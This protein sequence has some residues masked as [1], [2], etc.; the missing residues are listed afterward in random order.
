MRCVILHYHILKNAGTAIE[1]VLDRNFG[2]R[3]SRFDMTDRDG[4]VSR[5]ELLSLLQGN[6][7][8]QAVSSHQIRYPVPE[9]AG[10]LF[11]DLCFLRD[12]IDRIRS[13]YDYFRE[14][15]SP[16]DPVSGFAESMSLGD[17]IARLVE[18]DFRYEVTD[19]QVSLLA[20][21]IVDGPPPGERELER[22]T[23]RMMRMS[24]PGVV[25]RF[26]ESLV[27]GQH[28]LSPV[29]P[30][31]DCA[32][33]AVNVTR[34]MGSTLEGRVEKLKNTC[35]ARVFEELLRLNAL[36]LELLRRTRAEVLRRLAMVPEQ[37]LRLRALRDYSRNRCA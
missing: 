3:L 11:F 23:R 34:G 16:G 20:N 33:P 4:A 15:P 24:F 9:A 25:D 22:A 21:G 37:A 29:F 19:V 26:D 17:F 7:H 28:F 6:P 12:P 27:A 10:F 18:P 31:L 13:M 36:D 30:T 8:L 5:A 35:G 2:E 14:K 1:E 32:Q